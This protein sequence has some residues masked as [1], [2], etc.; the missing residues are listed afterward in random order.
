[1]SL[2]YITAA[3]LQYRYFVIFPFAVI[4]G[5]IVTII[6]GFFASLGE[7]D[8]FAIYFLVVFA[9]LVSDSILY[10]VG[11]FSRGTFLDRWGKYIG[12]TAEK[13][14]HVE[15]HFKNHPIKT[16]IAGKVSLGIGNVALIAAGVA[17]LKFGKYI[18]LNFIIELPKAL[19]FLL[20]GF[21]FG[22]AYARI[23]KYLDYTAIGFIVLAGFFIFIYFL[24][25]I[26]ARRL[27]DVEE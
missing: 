14:V 21:Y 5:P 22:Q 27:S 18:G 15:N 3:I 20:V 17:R 24:A 16:L 6:G 4:E 13:L 7:F 2:A 19:I 9:N 8:V 12:V 11:Y 25:R 23:A 26:F 1:M 10:C